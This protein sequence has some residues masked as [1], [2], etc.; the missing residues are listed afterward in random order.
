MPFPV[1]VVG[2][3][4]GAVALAGVGLRLAALAKKKSAPAA[5]VLPPVPSPPSPPPQ[6]IIVP[7]SPL[8]VEQALPALLTNPDGTPHQ[9]GT[10]FVFDSNSSAADAVAEANRRGISVH[11]L[12]IE[13]SGQLGGS[14]GTA[15]PGQRA[16]VTTNDP[17]PS[18]DLIIRS[19][20]SQSASQIGGAEKDA[21]VLILDARTQDATFA[22]ISWA[23]GPRRPPAE[24]FAK[25]AFLTLL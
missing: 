23:G 19:A 18:G 5:T 2:V 12:L 25:K 22:K 24:G 10:P 17:A 14:D 16:R 4:L 3:G 7:P 9:Q 6:G 8:Q 1:A 13:Q 20:P 15:V 11:Q 21:I